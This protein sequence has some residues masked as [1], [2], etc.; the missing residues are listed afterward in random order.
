M[1]LSVKE[2]CF[3]KSLFEGLILQLLYSLLKI[4][5][6]E[7]HFVPWRLLVEVLVEAFDALSHFVEVLQEDDV[8][9]IFLF[10]FGLGLF[11]RKSALT[12]LCLREFWLLC[13]L[14]WTRSLVETAIQFILILISFLLTS[15]L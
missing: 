3:V 13:D 10:A 4:S 8:A 15:S 9:N 5:F 11:P 1:G 2:R 12:T 7:I 14:R 6:D